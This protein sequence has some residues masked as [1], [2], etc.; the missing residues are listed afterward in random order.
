MSELQT[1]SQTWGYD[2]SCT[3]VTHETPDGEVVFTEI[4]APPDRLASE[5]EK[6]KEKVKAAARNK[7]LAFRVAGA[8]LVALMLLTVGLISQD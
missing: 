2:P 5:L 1:N 8:T 7:W 4:E 3:R 6:R